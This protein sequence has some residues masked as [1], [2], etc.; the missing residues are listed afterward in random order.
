MML[1]FDYNVMESNNPIDALESIARENKWPLE[2][3]SEEEASLEC[4]GRFGHFTLSFL[5]EEEYQALQF[6][7]VSD[8]AVSQEKLPALKELMF[9]INQK[10]WLGHFVLDD[11]GK[12]IAFRYNSLL[13]A[14]HVNDQDHIEDLID[15][16]MTEFDRFYP[17]LQAVLQRPKVANDVM[18]TML[19]DTMGEA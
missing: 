13:R 10:V 2:K 14:L 15:L 17:A 9:D 7:C 6:S 5:W 12:F 3:Q 11:E 18:A 16:A 1:D 8:L 19:A 4:E